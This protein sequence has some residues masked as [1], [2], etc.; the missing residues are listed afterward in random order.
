MIG[1]LDRFF[2]CVVSYD[3]KDGARIEKSGLQLH[4]GIHGRYAL[5]GGGPFIT[6]KPH[7]G[8][9]IG[10]SLAATYACLGALMALRHHDQ[11]GEEE[12]VD[13]A[14]YEG[15]LAMMGPVVPEYTQADFIHERTGYFLP[16]LAPSNAYP[17]L[18]GDLIICVNQD[19]IFGR[20]CDAMG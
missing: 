12:V 11:T 1:D 10:D 3:G 9:S 19:S 6:T 17:T 2:F 16:K 15:A 20:I 7:C 8:L 4:L 18:D 13:S 14:I 5:S